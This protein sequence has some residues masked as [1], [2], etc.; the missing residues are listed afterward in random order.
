MVAVV[1]DIFIPGFPAAERACVYGR[2]VF[3][4]LES[5]KFSL[6]TAIYIFY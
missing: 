1:K 2:Q 4:I 5:S 6:N 3:H